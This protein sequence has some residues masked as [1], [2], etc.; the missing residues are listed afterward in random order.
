MAQGFSRFARELPLLEKLGL[1]NLN[2]IEQ[3][4][5]RHGIDCD[6]ERNGVVDVAT[7]A[8]H[9]SDLADQAVHL[10][11]LGQDVELWDRDHIQSEIHSPTYHGGLF[12]KQRAAVCDPARLV[13]GMKQVAL[14]AGVRIFEDTQ[15]TELVEKDKSVRDPGRVR[16]GPGGQGRDRHQRLPPC[17]ARSGTTWSRSTTTCSPPSP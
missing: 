4:V 9:V 14:D 7:Q 10:E 15:A 5:M 11:A 6:W 12:R 3:F 8:D 1:D 2:E 13:F 17:S 16:F